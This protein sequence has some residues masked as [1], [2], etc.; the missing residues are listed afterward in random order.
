MKDNIKI[1][2]LI[3]G[4]LAGAFLGYK[5]A[6]SLITESETRQNTLPVT[7]SQGLQ[8]GLTAIGALKQIHNIARKQD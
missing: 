1:I 6:Q 3:I 5:A 2:T 8:L 7:A 4:T